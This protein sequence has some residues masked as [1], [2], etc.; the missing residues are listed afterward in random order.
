MVSSGVGIHNLD[1]WIYSAAGQG[2]PEDRCGCN[3]ASE[4]VTAFNGFAANL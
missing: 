1:I 2:F 4:K 3:E